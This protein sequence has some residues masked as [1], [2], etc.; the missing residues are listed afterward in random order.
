MSVRRAS[1]GS[2]AA[3]ESPP[4]ETAGRL[5]PNVRALGAVSFLTDVSSEMIYPLLPRFVTQTL[6]AST[7]FLGAIEGAA[8]ATASLLKI[9]S[10][11]VSDRMERRKPLVVLGYAVASAARP[12]VAVA[13]TASQVLAVR[14]GDRFG[15]GLRTSPRDALLADSVPASDRGRAYGFH[16][17]ADHTGAVVG[18]LLAWALLTW[19]GAS[20]RTVFLLAAIPGALAVLVLVAKVKEVPRGRG[21]A[22][23]PPRE[24]SGAPSSARSGRPSPEASSDLTPRPAAGERFDP[25]A[26]VASSRPGGGPAVDADARPLGRVFWTYLGVLAVFTLGNCSDA[27]LLLRASDLG[28]AEGVV[29]LLWAA[30]HVVK[31]ASSTPA[32]ALSDRVGR[33]PLLVAG[34]LWFAAVYAGFALASQ[35]WHA[36]ALFLSYGLFFGLV[37]GAEKALVADLA[38]AGRRGAA[39]GW[40]H[41]VVGLTTLPASVLFGVL[42]D[43]VGPAQAFLFGASLALAAAAL[44]A[45]VVRRARTAS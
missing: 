43:R 18:P 15:K 10:G 42:W 20:L 31:A 12:L 6:Q 21:R 9:V 25:S 17:A 28:V 32:G 29:P 2:P 14:V 16:R 34:W 33:K 45:L 3:S 30:H 27:F 35:A 36:W 4:A 40:F 44:L 24:E 8:E 11:R 13:T 26:D 5:P 38:P 41:G 23:T 1:G 37:E 22:A 19:A 39:F 7:A